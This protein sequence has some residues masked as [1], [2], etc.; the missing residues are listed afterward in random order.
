M[1]HNFCRVVSRTVEPLLLITAAGSFFASG[2]F[3]SIATLPLVARTLNRF[4]PPA[5]VFESMQLTMFSE[6]LPNLTG[7]LFMLP[8]AAM[9]GVGF[10]VWRLR[11]AL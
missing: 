8:V 5:Y 1:T 10:G 11:Q 9:L 6:V 3:S 2:G 7:I 4:W